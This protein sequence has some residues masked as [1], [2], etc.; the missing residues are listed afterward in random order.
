MQ[1]CIADLLPSQFHA[2]YEHEE[3]IAASYKSK[4]HEKLCVHNPSDKAMRVD[5]KSWK[6]WPR[7]KIV[8]HFKFVYPQLTH[9]ADKTFLKMI[10]EIKFVYDLEEAEVEDAFLTE[11]SKMKEQ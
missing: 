3:V 1:Q 8:E 10:K 11:L 5:C 9:V 6:S 7:L 4:F 2:H